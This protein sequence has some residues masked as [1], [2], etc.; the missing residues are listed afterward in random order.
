MSAT[1]AMLYTLGR[2][3][4]RRDDA[5]QSYL[6]VLPHAWRGHIMEPEDV[7]DQVSEAAEEHDRAEEAADG[8]FRK[9]AALAIGTLAMLLAITGLGGD[10]ATKEMVNANIQASDTWAFYQAKNVRQTEYRIAL[11]AL[12][13]RLQTDTTL[14]PDQRSAIEKQ[15]AS[16]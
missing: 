13:V 16:Y 1:G 5:G 14:T 6:T 9:R 4:W 12:Q 11:D 7:A 10:N 15:A 8:R 3:V 2:T